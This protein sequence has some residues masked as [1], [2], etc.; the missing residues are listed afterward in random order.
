MPEKTIVLSSFEDIEEFVS[1]AERC[2]FPVSLVRTGDESSFDGKSLL[3]VV[4]LLDWNIHVLYEGENAAL[5]EILM[6]HRV[7]SL[8]MGWNDYV[9]KQKFTD[10]YLTGLTEID[11]EHRQLVKHFN[12]FADACDHGNAQQVRTL[13]R[14]LK[15]FTYKHF[16]S[17]IGLQTDHGYPEIEAHKQEHLKLQ[18]K[19]QYLESEIADI[20]FSHLSSFIYD[21][22]FPAFFEHTLNDDVAFCKYILKKQSEEQESQPE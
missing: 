21:E 11:N 10:A 9:M 20:S 8:N 22:L 19:I 4:I 16:A 18:A 13:F 5:E 15:E 1:V 2:D 6:K 12:Y 3:S 17:E 14:Y 7:T